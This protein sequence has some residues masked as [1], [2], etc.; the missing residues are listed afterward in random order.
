MRPLA[1]EEWD[2]VTAEVDEFYG[3]GRGEILFWSAWPTPDLTR[4]GWKLE[5]HPPLM[6]RSA[7][8]RAPAPP[9]GLRVQ[10]IQDAEGLGVFDRVGA[11]GFPLPEL[12]NEP[13]GTMHDEAV[14]EDERLA[15]WVGWQ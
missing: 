7:G 9:E 5:G 6:Y 10:H 12:Q 3:A 13:P 15:Y 4:Y 14:L 11:L 8:G 1:L 2:G